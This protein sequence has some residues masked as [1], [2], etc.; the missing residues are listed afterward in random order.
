MSTSLNG[1]DW[2]VGH[3][4]R[5]TKISNDYE[6][7]SVSLPKSIFSFIKIEIPATILDLPPSLGEIWTSPFDDSYYSLDVKRIALCP[8][9]CTTSPG[10]ANKILYEIDQNVIARVAWRTT[11]DDSF[12]TDELS[13]LRLIPDGKKHIYKILLPAEGTMISDMQLSQFQVL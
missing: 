5:F 9:C 2:I 8:F 1:K 6:I 10:D 11:E 12:K 3:I 4:L 13:Y 7:R